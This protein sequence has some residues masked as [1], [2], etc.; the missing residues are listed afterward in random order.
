MVK[1]KWPDNSHN[2]AASTVPEGSFKFFQNCEEESI[3]D[4]V[5]EPADHEASLR[6]C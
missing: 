5:H 2:P 3:P 6:V 4:A 1:D